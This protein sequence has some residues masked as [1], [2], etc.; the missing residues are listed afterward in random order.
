MTPTLKVRPAVEQDARAIAEVHVGSWQEAYR[1]M[2]PDSYLA[3][4][5]IDKRE[6]AWREALVRGSPEVWVSETESGVGGWVSF[7]P[8]RD[9][10][11][12]PSVAEIEAIYVAPNRWATG[13]GRELW[14]AAQKR[15]VE[16]QFESVTLWVLEENARAIRFYSAAGFA[17]DAARKEV[18]V[19]GK[20]VWH[21]RYGRLLVAPPAEP[22]QASV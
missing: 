13:M 21:I 8:S 22:S 5:S 17:P 11:A 14:L 9:T 3:G 4:L 1:G 15:L 7:G 10:G 19:G 16:R 2:L 20:G 6:A 12:A 18:N